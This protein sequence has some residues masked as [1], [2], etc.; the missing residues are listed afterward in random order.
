MAIPPQFLKNVKAHMDAGASPKEAVGK[1]AGG[2]PKCPECGA[3]MLGGKCPKCGYVKPGADD[4][5]GDEG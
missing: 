3:P 4:D 1:A 2:L 5:D